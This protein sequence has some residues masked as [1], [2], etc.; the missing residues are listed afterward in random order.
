M[1]N[2]AQALEHDWHSVGGSNF[3]F[4]FTPKYRRKVFRDEHLRECCKELA[5]QKAA[6]LG[7]VIEAM[8]YGPDHVHLFTRGCRNYSVAQLAQ[9]FKGYI[10]REIRKREP[11]RVNRHL[12]GAPFWSAG[13]FYESVG[14]VT[15]ETVRYYIARQQKKHW[16][17]GE[18]G[19]PGSQPAPAARG[20]LTLD[21]FA[22]G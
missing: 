12:S 17:P 3:H 13:Y 6:E 2:P 1:E 7:I 16:A 9:Y 20:Q 11:E 10:S 5:Y 14:R 22:A 4:Q 19:V 21:R 15:S 18:Y 8:E